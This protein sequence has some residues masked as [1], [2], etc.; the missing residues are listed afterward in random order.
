[1]TIDELW[2]HSPRVVIVN[3]TRIIQE[4]VLQSVDAIFLNTHAGITPMYRGVHTSDNVTETVSSGAGRVSNGGLR[5]MYIER[6][7]MYISDILA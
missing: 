7:S 1:M 3:G 4:R 5:T 2:R 6:D